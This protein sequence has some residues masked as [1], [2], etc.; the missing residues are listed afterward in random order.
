MSNGGTPEQ[1]VVR[2][3]KPSVA[4]EGW[5]PPTISS[6]G[7]TPCKW[8]K[9]DINKEALRCPECSTWQSSPY[10]P[11]ALLVGSLITAFLMPVALLG[12]TVLYQERDRAQEATRTR[13][14]QTFNEIKAIVE[15]MGHYQE[16]EIALAIDC[17]GEHPG[18]HAKDPDACLADYSQR[19]A[20]M[21]AFVAR[22]SW[23]VSAAPVSRE[24]H[25]SVREWQDE[26]WNH[27]RKRLATTYGQ[28]RMRGAGQLTSVA[29]P[30]ATYDALVRTCTANPLDA[31][32]PNLLQCQQ[33][34]FEHSECVTEVRAALQPFSDR[35][36]PAFCNIVSSLDH[37]RLD[38]L[39]QL[40]ASSA[41]LDDFSD[42]LL[43]SKCFPPNAGSDASA[44]HK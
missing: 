43:H 32:C 29:T 2:E 5:T 25:Q 27:T 9:T 33:N 35:T 21:D 38:A 20:D 4:T 23:A 17:K 19:L 42:R 6:P 44:P 24:A 1:S 39:R 3:P 18:D 7:K 40:N 31:S 15:T 36:F 34:G 37:A 8:C 16:R 28:F 26:W 13:L 11:S 30:Q 14:D 41:S 22:L 10:G 12:V